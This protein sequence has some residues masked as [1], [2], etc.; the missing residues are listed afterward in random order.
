MLSR[1]YILWLKLTQCYAN[2][3]YDTLILLILSTRYIDNAMICIYFAH[4]SNLTS[5]LSF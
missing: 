2:H 5:W 4:Y 3:C 1:V